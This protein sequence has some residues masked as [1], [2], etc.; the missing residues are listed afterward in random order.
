MHIKDWY[1]SGYGNFSASSRYRDGLIF[2]ANVTFAIDP[3]QINSSKL[4]LEFASLC[5][6]NP[7]ESNISSSTKKVILFIK[8]WL[9][10]EFQNSHALDF[11]DKNRVSFFN[12]RICDEEKS[13]CLIYGYDAYS[14]KGNHL[15]QVE[16]DPP[17]Y[18]INFGHPFHDEL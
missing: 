8:N 10:D 16:C 17:P 9:I 14:R 6:Q 4:Y 18:V 7:V 5:E 13:F 3:E 11:S 15:I 12:M 2:E 1:V